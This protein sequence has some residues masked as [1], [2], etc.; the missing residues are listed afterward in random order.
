[1]KPALA[2]DLAIAVTLHRPKQPRFPRLLRQLPTQAFVEIIASRHFHLRH[3]ASPVHI[4]GLF[5][6][7]HAIFKVV[8][9]ILV[10]PPKHVVPKCFPNPFQAYAVAPGLF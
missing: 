10:T 9:A 3:S 1:V 8:L 4:R 6:I 2:R 7:P 5:R